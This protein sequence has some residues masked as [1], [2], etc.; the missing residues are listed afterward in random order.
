MATPNRLQKGA[1]WILSH[2]PEGYLLFICMIRVSS[3]MYSPHLHGIP[4][5]SRYRR[6]SGRKAFDSPDVVPESAQTKF[7]LIM[8]LNC[9]QN[10]GTAEYRYPKESNLTLN[11]KAQSP[12]T[13]HP[14]PE[15]LIPNPETLKYPKP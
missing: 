9:R 10:N 5:A 8:V 11:P 1:G 2:S 12:Y 6:G 7:P 14:E 13:L 3:V 4:S 15:L